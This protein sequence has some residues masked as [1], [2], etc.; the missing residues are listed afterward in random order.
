MGVIRGEFKACVAYRVSFR[1]SRA[2]QN[3]SKTIKQHTHTHRHTHKEF[4]E[5]D[6]RDHSLLALLWWF[7]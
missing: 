5:G 2:I 3:I 4:V 1:I 6:Q 7:K